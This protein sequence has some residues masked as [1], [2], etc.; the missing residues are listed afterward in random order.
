MSEKSKFIN[1]EKCGKRL[2]E[3]FGGVYHFRFGKN[4]DL[5]STPVDMYVSGAIKMKCI[6]KS[7]NHWNSINLLSVT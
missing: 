7:C 2:I 6:R 1:C 3:Y 5:D 4:E